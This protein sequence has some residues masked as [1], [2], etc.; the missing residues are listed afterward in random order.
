MPDDKRI[1]IGMSGGADSAVSASLLQNDGWDV[2]GLYL[3]LKKRRNIDKPSPDEKDAR[4]VSLILG[5]PFSSVDESAYFEK[6]I[7][8]PFVL[9]YL[10][11]RTP[12]P[13]I[14]CNPTVKFRILCAYAD[15]LGVKH[16]ATGHYVGAEFNE[17]YGKWVIKQGKDLKKD[18]SYFLGRLT[19]EQISRFITPL[20]EYSKSDISGLATAL[21]L[22]V[23]QKRSSQEICFINGH[24]S[25]F[26]LSRKESRGKIKDGDIC[27]QKGEIL[28]RH[29]G[30]PFYT[31][32]QRSGLR[33]SHS[34]PLYVLHLDSK[35]NRIIVGER[36]EIF[37]SALIAKDLCW[38][39]ISRI[40][41][42]IEADVKIRHRHKPAKA[43][44]I[45]V[46]DGKQVKV[47]FEKPQ[48]AVAPGQAVVFYD[49]DII[50]G[51]GIIVSDTK[52]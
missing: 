43:K 9:E 4:D 46:N 45:P 7:Q 5:I 17:N 40:S 42:E 39:A 6:N 51:S 19:Q 50:L 21:A 48:I 13:C 33:I 47:V 26:L 3:N 1:I 41:K 30:L 11:G 20:Y 22:P 28:G 24:Y 49:N 10:S 37:A 31:V 29:K 38:M 12:N 25:Q 44:I 36:E 27:N 18:Q 16:I 32:G 52:P 2:H 8:K 15:S 34:C 35:N 23:A 14:Y